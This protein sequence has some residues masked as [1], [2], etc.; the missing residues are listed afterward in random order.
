MRVVESRGIVMR[1]GKEVRT[2]PT[3]PS[4]PGT[5]RLRPAPVVRKT[6]ILEFSRGDSERANAT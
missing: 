1:I 5:G 2:G 4:I 3:M 6:T